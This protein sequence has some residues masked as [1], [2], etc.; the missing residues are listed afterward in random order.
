MEQ[1][2][3]RATGSAAG[4]QMAWGGGTSAWLQRVYLGPVMDSEDEQIRQSL[5]RAAWHATTQPGLQILLQAG[6][7]GPQDHPMCCSC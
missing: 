5:H 4:R 3:N 2:E 6:L 1:G 7:R